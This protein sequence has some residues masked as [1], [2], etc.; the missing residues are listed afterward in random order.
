MSK[1]EFQVSA[2]TWY[3]T[4][5]QTQLTPLKEKMWKTTTKITHPNKYVISFHSFTHPIMSHKKKI[6]KQVVDD[7]YC[8]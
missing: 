6:K 7:V 2:Y 8:D 5:S 4:L 3:S 1:F